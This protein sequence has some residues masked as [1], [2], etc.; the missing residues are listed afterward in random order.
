[1]NTTVSLNQTDHLAFTCTDS[2]PGKFIGFSVTAFKIFILLPIHIW[3]LWLGTSDIRKGGSL[4]TSDIFTVS[5]SVLELLTVIH[6]V[7]VHVSFALNCQLTMFI[8]ILFS[9][10]YLVG[11]PFMNSLTCVERYIAVAH[12]VMY[13][14][15][16]FVKHRYISAGLVWMLTLSYGGFFVLSFPDPPVGLPCLP[17]NQHLGDHYL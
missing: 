14:N 12:P 3:V 13:R 11:R 7:F 10:S 9:G 8:A 4:A 5:L 1:M 16:A 15:P 17:H 2:Y 6:F